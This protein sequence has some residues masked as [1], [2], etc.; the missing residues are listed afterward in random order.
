M[1]LPATLL[2]PPREPDAGLPPTGIRVMGDPLPWPRAGATIK[3][4][5]D[6]HVPQGYGGLTAKI[7]F[8]AGWVWRPWIHF[9][10]G[11]EAE[12]RQEKMAILWRA[13]NLPCF[14]E[15]PLVLRA[16]FIFARPNGHLDARGN[17]REKFLHTRPGGRGNKNREGQRTG[18]D[19]DNLCK[20]IGDALNKVA[21]KDDGQVA[22]I[23]AE[24]CYVDQAGADT[25]M[26]IFDLLP[27]DV[28]RS[29]FA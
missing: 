12:D 1:A 21:Y 7:L 14:E 4:G 3:P 19:T 24:K 29:A 6:I 18:G 15:G 22:R 11:A 13:A 10:V 28:S 20:L 27:L 2:D 26:T 23:E 8:A 9:Y 25:P 16:E 17:V 5:K